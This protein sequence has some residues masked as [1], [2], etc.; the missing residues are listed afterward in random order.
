LGKR[1]EF[2]GHP[3]N[4]IAKFAYY[5][6][7]E[8]NY[9]NA[10]RRLK[11]SRYFV[12]EHYTPEIEAKRKKLYPVMRKAWKDHKK[13]KLVRDSLYID[14]KLYIP[15]EDDEARD[16]R[17]QKRKTTRQGAQIMEVGSQAKREPHAY[18]SAVDRDRDRE[19]QSNKRQRQRT[20]PDR[21]S[22]HS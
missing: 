1:D 10:P 2:R 12:N 5:K 18:S 13:V 3:R 15:F 21:L 9:N 11:G 22:D 17:N 6:D 14:G 4:I 7:K 16:R 8:Y 19:R 20:T